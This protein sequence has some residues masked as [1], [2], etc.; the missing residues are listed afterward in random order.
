MAVDVDFRYGVTVDVENDNKKF[1]LN[2]EIIKMVYPCT[3]K[4]AQTIKMDIVY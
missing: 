3:K 2:K 4:F 1:K